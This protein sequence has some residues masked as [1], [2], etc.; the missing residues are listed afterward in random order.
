MRG[1]PTVRTWAAGVAILV[2]A[3]CATSS[4]DVFSST[5]SPFDYFVDGV[6]ADAKQSGASAEQIDLLEDARATGEV[7]IQHLYT[8]AELAKSCFDA[9]GVWG[10]F[11]QTD[12]NDPLRGLTYTVRVDDESS[13]LLADDCVTKYYDA[14]SYAFG[15]QPVAQE[16]SDERLLIARAAIVECA[17]THGEIIASDATPDELRR[18]LFR[19][20]NGFELGDV[21]G[22]PP[23]GFTPIDCAGPAGVNGY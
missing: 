15:L 13:E 2:C 23:E 11:E 14:V 6:I 12:S 3:G 8:A 9:A 20:R 1:T 19:L 4:P 21:Q 10:V 22:E 7:T 17:Q 16:R 5:A 18:I